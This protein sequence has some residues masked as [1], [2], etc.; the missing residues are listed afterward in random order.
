MGDIP[1]PDTTLTPN[2]KQA[3]RDTWKEIYANRKENGVALLLRLF[4]EYPETKQRFKNL[5]FLDDLEKLGKHPTMKAHAFRVMASLNSLVET[6]DDAEV[7]VE[8]LVNLGRTH[9]VK[10]VTESDFD[11]LGVVAIWLVENKS[12]SSYTEYAKAAWI[13][14]WGVI[15]SVIVKEL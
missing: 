11:K 10:N 4:S 1:D 9:K 15:Q 8:L 3:I 2:E 13:K 14:A 12:G 7:L 6:L 5:K